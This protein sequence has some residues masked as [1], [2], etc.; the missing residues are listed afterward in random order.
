MSWPQGCKVLLKLVHN[1]TYT[2]IWS[3][4][5]SSYWI[6]TDWE[7]ELHLQ[8]V[9][10]IVWQ[11]VNAKSHALLAEELIQL[12]EVLMFVTKTLNS[13]F[14]GLISFFKMFNVNWSIIVLEVSLSCV[15]CISPWLFE[16]KALW[17]RMNF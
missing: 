8:T 11:R 17:Y 12:W 16:L 10:W 2:Y 6:S 13:P 15:C 3:N 14:L 4:Y 9:C 5:V 7:L 1:T